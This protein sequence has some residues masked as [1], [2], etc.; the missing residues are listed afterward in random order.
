[1]ISRSTFGGDRRIEPGESSVT[2]ARAR[3]AGEALDEPVADLA[4]G[5]GDQ[6]DGFAHREIILNAS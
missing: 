2:M 3:L 6:D 1:M 4:A 5:A